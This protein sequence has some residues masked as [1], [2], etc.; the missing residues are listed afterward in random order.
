MDSSSVQLISPLAG[1]LQ[2]GVGCQ[3]ARCAVPFCLTTGFTPDL[4][5]PYSRR[6]R[7]SDECLSACSTLPLLVAD[8]QC[9]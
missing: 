2:G 7:P 3:L 9:R 5:Y 4:V 8:F 1:H 6:I